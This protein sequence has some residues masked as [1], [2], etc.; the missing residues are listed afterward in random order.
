MES[1]LANKIILVT[2]ASDGIGRAVCHALCMQGAKV[3]ALARRQTALEALYDD[4]QAQGGT[5]P[6]LHPFNLTSASAQDYDDLRIH[7]DKH[8]A[9]L[10]GLVHI[11]TTLGSITPIQQFEIQTWYEV[12]QT[13]LN[14]CFL[15]TRALLPQL[16]KPKQA[17][18]LFTLHPQATKASAYWG[19]YAVAAHGLK[20]FADIMADELEN[21]NIRVDTI[22]PP[23][24]RT[25]FRHKVY[26]ADLTT[27]LAEPEEVAES[28]L[29]ALKLHLAPA[30]TLTTA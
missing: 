15:L 29:N 19:A 18:I 12:M 21:T 22:T 2:G 1:N 4:I 7:I 28:Y 11:A 14:S 13:N 30:A 5:P 20:A 6:W 3:I 17:S 8:F 24:T 23:P 9:K 16:S 27:P 25:K 26:P 10:D